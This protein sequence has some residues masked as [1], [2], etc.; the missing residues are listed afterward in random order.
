MGKQVVVGGAVGA[1]FG[2]LFF[3]SP[4]MRRSC[5]F[6][7]AGVGIG[8]HAQRIMQLNKEFFKDGPV[9]EG[10]TNAAKPEVDLLKEIDKL[11][12]EVVLRSKLRQ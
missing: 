10:Q 4:S 7:G 1:T 5:F 11:E 3:K 9:E 12:K 8:T 6:F 2:L